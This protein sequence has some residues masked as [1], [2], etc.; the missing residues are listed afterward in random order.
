[1]DEPLHAGRAWKSGTTVVSPYK[2]NRLTSAITVYHYIPD[3]TFKA[4]IMRHKSLISDTK[5]PFWHGI[6]LNV[7]FPFHASRATPQDISDAAK[8]KE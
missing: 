1:M 7:F 4:Y 5:M 2:L 6:A 8:I 3:T